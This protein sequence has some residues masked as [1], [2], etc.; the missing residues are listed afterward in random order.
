MTALAVAI[1]G[2]Y[3]A[4]WDFTP[5]AGT[6]VRRLNRD[7]GNVQ[8]LWGATTTSAPS[9]A[10]HLVKAPG[11]VFAMAEV[12]VNLPPNTYG[13]PAQVVITQTG[14]PASLAPWDR[15]EW[16]LALI[17][18]EPLVTV[19]A[20]D[21]PVVSTMRST[22]NVN[23]A[24]IMILSNWYLDGGFASVLPDVICLNPDAGSLL[25]GNQVSIDGGR[26]VWLN[27]PPGC[28][29]AGQPFSIARIRS[30]GNSAGT[31][32]PAFT[33]AE[34]STGHL[35]NAGDS[36]WVL[37]DED[38][39]S[40]SLHALDV[41]DFTRRGGVTFAGTA[42]GPYVAVQDDGD[43]YAYSTFSGSVMVQGQSY[44]TSR[45]HN[46]VLARVRR[47]GGVAWVHAY[48]SVNDLRAT[49]VSF[50]SGTLAV[51]GTCFGPDGGT[52]NVVTDDYCTGGQTLS[53]FVLG[54][55]P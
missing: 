45:Q 10:L 26:A 29:D 39:P 50:S 54:L 43:A 32:Y 21:E 55:V 8:G 30:V 22:R 14:G 40:T 37:L 35:F 28:Q 3:A 6:T 44:T 36:A 51:A 49:A 46:L 9:I 23:G 17:P 42:V 4:G 24:P 2:V 52:S 48:P 25:T 19:T 12:P 38:Q 34:A 20:A 18:P 11:G 13:N 1:D 53:T 33:R 31:V 27:R 5:P 15:G 47:D 41:P 7:T 16:P